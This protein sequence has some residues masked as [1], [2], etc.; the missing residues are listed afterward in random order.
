MQ[1]ASSERT[2]HRASIIV[3][4]MWE[5]LGALREA[6]AALC[7]AV[8]SEFLV[9]SPPQPAAVDEWVAFLARWSY[10]LE[11]IEAIRHALTAC[12]G[13]A[14]SSGGALGAR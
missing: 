13:A 5:K 8:E 12:G 2:S 7:Q 10:D 3:R 1:V 9:E 6:H 11:Q 14:P 4:A